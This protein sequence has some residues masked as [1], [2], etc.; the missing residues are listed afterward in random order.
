MT[1]RGEGQKGGW[2]PRHPFGAKG[3]GVLASRSQGPPLAS[4]PAPLPLPRVLAWSGNV[5]ASGA[6]DGTIIL[7]DVRSTTRIAS[8]TP[9]LGEVWAGVE[10]AR[11]VGGGL[12]SGPRCPLQPLKR[13]SFLR[14]GTGENPFFNL[15]EATPPVG[16]R[17]LQKK[18]QC[19]SPSAL[20]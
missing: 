8:V 20:F 13:K 14:S 3:G 9:H 1:C 7:H 19:R 10:Q 17:G 5:L 11:E 18:R 2:A 15:T 12:P 6:R 4:L 16:P